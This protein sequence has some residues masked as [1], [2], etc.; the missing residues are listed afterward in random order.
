MI[1]D[2]QLYQYLQE[3][4]IIQTSPINLNL[5]GNNGEYL[6]TWR[7]QFA[8]L[9]EDDMYH[10]L[11][12]II[13]QLMI[14]EMSEERRL[15]LM[16]EV[17]SVGQHLISLLHVSYWN[18]AGFLNETQQR[19]LDKVLSICYLSIIFYHS[20]W[21]R[22][23]EQI[24]TNSGSQFTLSA[25]F[26]R[27]G[28][29][30]ASPNDIVKR[31]LHSIVS[32]L[33]QA[34]TEKQIGYR[35][36][37]HVVWHYL[38]IYYNFAYHCDW[39]E[40]SYRDPNPSVKRHFTIQSLY[41]QCLLSE[42]VNPYTYRRHDLLALSQINAEWIKFLKISREPLDAP[43][44]YVNLQGSEPPRLLHA[45][46][47]FNPFDPNNQ[48]LFISIQPLVHKLTQLIQAPITEKT[49]MTKVRLA[50]F[51]LK[52]LQQVLEPPI[53]FE[54]M[55]ED[56]QVVFGFHHIHYLLSGRSSLSNLIQSHL[57]PERLRPIIHTETNFKKPMNANLLGHFGRYRKLIWQF[58]YDSD[59]TEIGN[60]RIASYSP[61]NQFQNNSMIA[62]SLKNN[63]TKTGW[64]LGQVQSLKQRPMADELQSHTQNLLEDNS[65]HCHLD[66]EVTVSLVGKGIV[67]CGVRILNHDTRLPRFMPAL[68]IPHSAET[69]K[70]QTTLMMARFGYRV[71]DKLIIRIDNKEV[72]VI[73]N[74]L[75]S[76]T[77]DIEEYT[78]SRIQ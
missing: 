38:N 33:K 71:E 37:T 8:Q 21:K 10:E 52:N 61:V 59:N 25:L 76:M 20:V 36:D 24:Q 22:L 55:N 58:V 35:Q 40:F 13:N 53:E 28:K 77:D 56:C 12:Y 2:Q 31:C 63:Q 50:N 34:L 48:S 54:D 75:V 5:I 66:I 41:L 19:S 45:K 1:S 29:F 11:K 43:F 57:L 62:I 14:A 70:Q 51:T 78:F 9:S 72:K 27:F 18:Q 30:S 26:R 6:T 49:N 64:Q 74:E 15:E 23:S 46:V 42:I 44:L 16:Q 69:G 73:L 39:H 47:T 68:I 32:L 17:L 60:S 67:P 65:I 3:D 7:L 4:T